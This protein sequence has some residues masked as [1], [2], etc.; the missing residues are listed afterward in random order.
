VDHPAIRN[1]LSTLAPATGQVL[2]EPLIPAHEPESSRYTLMQ[3]RGEGGLGRVWLARDRDLHRGVALKEIRPDRASNPE[4]WRRFLK[5]A[6]IT[7]QLEHPHIVPVYELARRRED[8][9]PFYTMRYVR[10]QTLRG[11]I[12]EFHRQRAGKA[13]DWLALQSLLGSFLKVC[14]AIAYAHSR[15]VVHRDLKPENIVLGAYGEVAVLDWGL[16]KLV[17]APVEPRDPNDET[18]GPI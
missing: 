4:L 6:Q 15:G 3:I 9:Q 17:D 13:P 7:G 14:D 8:D 12:Q 16:A 5:E 18:V 11:A 1:S 2:L 10:G